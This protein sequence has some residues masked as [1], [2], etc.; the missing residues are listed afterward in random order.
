MDGE[1]LRVADLDT[2]DIQSL[3]VL[4]DFMEIYTLS[5]IDDH[6]TPS[7]ILSVSDDLR[8]GFGYS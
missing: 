1:E 4:E 2:H 6:S 3:C 7:S 5:Y 8:S